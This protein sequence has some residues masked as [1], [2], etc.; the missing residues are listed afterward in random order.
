MI[1]MVL[2]V[3]LSV[4]SCQGS[5]V[6]HIYQASQLAL[7]NDA[8]AR[9][10][11]VY[12]GDYSEAGEIQLTADGTESAP[13]WILW[14]D[15]NNS[16]DQT[17][18]VKLNVGNE[19]LIVG[20]R[21]GISGNPA[22]HWIVHRVTVRSGQVQFRNGSSN[23]VLS[24]MLIEQ[25]GDGNAV[26][27][28]ENSDNNV[29]QYTVIRDTKKM[30]GKDN[31]CIGLSTQKNTQILSNEIYDCAGDSIQ[32][33]SSSGPY[34]VRDN[35]IYITPEM[36]TNCAGVL[37]ESGDCACA[38]N[39]I[40][41]KGPGGR[42]FPLTEDQWVKIENNRIWG[43]R[44]SDA[45]CATTGSRGESIQIGSGDTN[46]V[47]FVLVKNNAI[48]DGVTAVAVGVA[49]VNNV[50][51]QG[52]FIA[53]MTHGK[54]EH[55]QAAIQNISGDTFEMYSNII[56]SSDYWFRNKQNAERND[57]RCN[58]LIDSNDRP[59]QDSWA[60]DSQADYNFFYNTTEYGTETPDHNLVFPAASDAQH[61]DLRI[62]RK[63]LTGP[64][65]AFLPFGVV[66]SQSPQAFACDPFIG[67]RLGIGVDDTFGNALGGW[68]G[69]IQ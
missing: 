13:R 44:P 57:V 4:P 3:A 17:H 67:Q 31:H 19:A 46:Q 54:A 28:T 69:V 39:A 27:I 68:N 20:L 61:S 24:N 50:S 52:N 56:A 22:N 43:F 25:P 37:T 2:A 45:A 64:E 65:V 30:P 55:K 66:S 8:P 5:D 6:M 26:T 34:V 16:T 23:N 58:V 48:W 47:D 62:E 63:R 7:I 11:C 53:G 21:F 33:F 1:A 41:F 18:P 40:D 12:P 59:F 49:T 60:A 42:S 32:S 10:F 15:P 51:V 14:Y 38:E 35:D 29:I 36:Y 9:V